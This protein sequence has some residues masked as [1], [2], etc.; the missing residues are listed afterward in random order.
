MAVRRLSARQL[1]IVAALIVVGFFTY[2]SGPSWRP[3]GSGDRAPAVSV[4]RSGTTPAHFDRIFA[5]GDSL[6]ETLFNPDFDMPTDENPFG[7]TYPGITSTGGPNW[8]GYLIHDHLKTTWLYN[9]AMG[10][11]QVSSAEFDD[12]PAGNRD[13]SFQ[14]DTLLS[15]S[16][17]GKA[18]TWKPETTLFTSWFGANDVH[19]GFWRMKTHDIHD[20]IID[21][22]L[23][24]LDRLVA[25]G[26]KNFLVMT[27]ERKCS[28][29]DLLVSTNLMQPY[30]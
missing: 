11:A 10:G 18:P 16:K 25:L 6:S 7:N 29:C 1:V 15:K 3:S 26:A 19:N 13:M 28:H 27:P 12:E 17:A 30:T 2:Q 23:A 24:Q 5:F 21:L 22:W 8:L 20:H 9:L 14:V 4:T